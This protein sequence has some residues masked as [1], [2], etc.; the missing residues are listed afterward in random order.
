MYQ[1]STQKAG[2]TLASNCGILRHL[3]WPDVHITRIHVLPC[4]RDHKK[5]WIYNGLCPSLK[6]GMRRALSR[7]GIQ[8]RWARATE[9]QSNFKIKNSSISLS[10]DCP[11]RSDDPYIG[12]DIHVDGKNTIL[13]HELQNWG[14][15]YQAHKVYMHKSTYNF[16]HVL[17]SWIGESIFRFLY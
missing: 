1:L 14:V 10:T 4:H 16:V 2:A 12:Q 9:E 7:N 15:L 6:N 17:Y 8:P 3:W 5:V 13:K 11:T